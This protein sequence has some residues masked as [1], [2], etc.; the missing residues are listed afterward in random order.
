M[1]T[2]ILGIAIAGTLSAVFTGF[3]IAGRVRENQR[4]TQIILEKLETIRL[5]NW[6]QVTAP[7]FIPESFSERF[8]PQAPQRQGITY[9]GTFSV[10]PFPFAT[11]YQDDMREVTVTLQWKSERGIPRSR[12]FVTYIARDGIQNYVY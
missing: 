4:A 11:S 6:S 1:T 7:G 10:A 3:L 8:D 5:Y 12:S 2:M 9:Y